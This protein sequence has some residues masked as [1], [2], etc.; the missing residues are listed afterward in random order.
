MPDGHTGT[1]PQ[2]RRQP[3]QR[4]L[5]SLEGD[6]LV[7]EYGSVYEVHTWAELAHIAVEGGYDVYTADLKN[8]DHFPYLLDA[9]ADDQATVMASATGGLLGIRLAAGRATRW[10]GGVG[11]WVE[12]HGA[13]GH[14]LGLLRR[15]FDYVGVGTYPTPGS[16]GEALWAALRTE[17]ASVPNAAAAHDLRV[18]AF[19][20]RADTPYVGRLPYAYEIDLRSAYL[21][22]AARLPTYTA[23]R[24]LREESYARYGDCTYYA[25]CRITLER[26]ITG[27]GP[28]PHR[29]GGDP[30][31]RHPLTYPRTAGATFTAWL[32]KE[33]IRRARRSGATVEV[34]RGWLWPLWDRD[35]AGWIERMA[36]LRY[37]APDAW[38]ELALKK[39]SVAAIGRHKIAP[40][41]YS[42]LWHD[43]P[44]LAEDDIPLPL[45]APGAPP[46]S[47]A[48]LH[49]E[50]HPNPP[51]RLPHWWNYITMR[52][53][54]ALHDRT[55]LERK[56]GNRVLLT[57]FDSILLEQMSEGPTSQENTPGVWRETKLDDVDIRAARSF[58]SRQK[59]RLP[60]VPR[61]K[62]QE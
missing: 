39:A 51:P 56:A 1:W 41:N 9:I 24:L 14:F 31:K 12:G 50:P 8:P 47:G 27:L 46:I 32:W 45:H 44:R 28:V 26:D 25:E 54:V 48:W 35:N 20:G 4:L 29:L 36:Q 52:C 61:N 22:F 13:G 55:E 6:R 21:A 2:P 38:L 10:L 18:H 59:T 43:D 57:N 34:G 33:E 60:G 53:R 19:G 30:G 16:L 11:S 23:E 5:A 7:D 49:S 42:L 15:L 37:D 40:V 17:R 62:R 58:T 3:R